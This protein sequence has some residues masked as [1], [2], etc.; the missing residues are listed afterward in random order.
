MPIRIGSQVKSAVPITAYRAFQLSLCVAISIVFAYALVVPLPYF[1]PLFALLL[2]VKPG[3]AINSKALVALIIIICLSLGIGLLLVPLLLKY[4]A[5]GM[6]IVAMGL[7]FSTYIAIIKGQA[8]LGILLT[9]GITL[10]SAAGLVDYTLATTV[11]KALCFAVTIAIISQWLVYPLFPLSL[12]KDDI[13]IANTTQEKPQESQ[14]SNWIAIQTTL[15]VLPVY[16]LTLTN[17]LSYMAIIMKGVILGQ[18]SSTLNAK[19]AARELLGSTFLAGLFAIL[20]WLLL[21]S[22]TTLWMY[23]AGLF[24]FTL[25]FVSK[26]YQI[27]ASRFPPSFWQN[28]FVT[29]I[30]LIGPAVEDSATGKDVYKA[31]AYRMTLFIGLSIYACIAVY[32]LEWLRNRLQEKPMKNIKINS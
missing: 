23:A 17:P 22:V 12:I 25:Y 29:M 16:F 19:H 21:T 3:P 2:A 20:F 31:F 7:Y 27:I 6:L 4:K 26:L 28:V 8:L 13:K 14:S 18:Q 5:A 15:I 1:S 10:I 9:M 11:I 32:F 30:I 24:L